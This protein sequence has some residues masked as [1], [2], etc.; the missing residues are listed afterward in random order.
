MSNKTQ[1]IQ[2]TEIFMILSNKQK[3][4][5]LYFSHSLLCYNSLYVKFMLIIHIKL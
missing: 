5:L 1:T 3:C 2:A 4:Y